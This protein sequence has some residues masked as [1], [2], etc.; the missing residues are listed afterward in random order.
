[1]FGRKKYYVTVREVL[2]SKR[3]RVAGPFRTREEAQT[4]RNELHATM[5]RESLAD[6]RIGRSLEEIEE[7]VRRAMRDY[8]VEEE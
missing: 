4:K 8:Q 6:V 5:R 1:M 3:T 2:T 7:H